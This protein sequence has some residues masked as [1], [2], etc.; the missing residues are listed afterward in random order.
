MLDLGKNSPIIEH[1]GSLLK[2]MEVG[3]VAPEMGVEP[4]G[5]G[6]KV[7]VLKKRCGEEVDDA[8]IMLA[9]CPGSKSHHS[10]IVHLLDEDGWTLPIGT[11]NHEGGEPPIVV[12]KPIG[13]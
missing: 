4:V 8:G 5:K 1:D 9:S 10:A 2:Q 7:L 12:L 3:V 11:R 6:L 13:A